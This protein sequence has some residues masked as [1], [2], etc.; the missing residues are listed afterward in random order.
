MIVDPTADLDFVDVSGLFHGVAFPG[1]EVLCQRVQD[2]R[3]ED[4]VVAN[5]GSI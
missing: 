5:L 3:A 4:H 2:V 1:E